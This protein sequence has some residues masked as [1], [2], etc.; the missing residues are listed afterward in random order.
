MPES[1]REIRATNLPDAKLISNAQVVEDLDATFKSCLFQIALVAQKHLEPLHQEEVHQAK[2]TSFRQLRE[3]YEAFLLQ[4]LSPE[5]LRSALKS[6][7]NCVLGAT[8][9]SDRFAA[10]EAERRR[11]KDRVL[12]IGLRVSVLP[13]KGKEGTIIAVTKGFQGQPYYQIEM[14]EKSAEEPQI[15]CYARQLQWKE[16]ENGT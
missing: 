3:M 12:E 16:E 10:T 9:V 1:V 4:Q 2:L 6:L 7:N 15:F 8:V 14:D 11:M 13:L 5:A